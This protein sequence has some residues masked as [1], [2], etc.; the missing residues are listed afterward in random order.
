MQ[1]KMSRWCYHQKTPKLKAKYVISPLGVSLLGSLRCKM[2]R[3]I[4]KNLNLLD[5]CST[6]Q[7]KLNEIKKAISKS[8]F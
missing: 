5:F 2:K 6:F 7:S 8:S 4:I 3:K 1:K